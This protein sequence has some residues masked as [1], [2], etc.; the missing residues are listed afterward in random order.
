MRH[1]LTHWLN[2]SIAAGQGRYFSN[3]RL[4]RELA[5]FMRV[6]VDPSWNASVLAS[7]LISTAESD[8]ASS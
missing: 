1:A 7:V 2:G 3:E 4:I 5:S 6:D 8:D